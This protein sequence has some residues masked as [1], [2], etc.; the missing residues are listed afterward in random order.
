MLGVA[1]V[2]IAEVGAAIV[3]LVCTSSDKAVGTRFTDGKAANGKF[4]AAVADTDDVIEEGFSHDA[5]DV[6][7]VDASRHTRTFP[8]EPDETK[9][10]AEPVT[11]ASFRRHLVSRR[12]EK[13]CCETLKRRKV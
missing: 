3:A 7:V 12:V 6:A 11:I 10:S 4:E 8:L 5:I 1:V 2:G 9:T 13:G